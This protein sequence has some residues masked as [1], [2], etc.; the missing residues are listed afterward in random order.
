MKP[1]KFDAIPLKIATFLLTKNKKTIFI[2][3]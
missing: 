1:P 3:S 2:N